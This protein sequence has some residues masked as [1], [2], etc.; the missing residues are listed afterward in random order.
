MLVAF[1][2]A[3][4]AQVSYLDPLIWVP[5]HWRPIGRAVRST[6]GKDEALLKAYISLTNATGRLSLIV[7]LCRRCYNML[8]YATVCVRACFVK[9]HQLDATFLQMV[10]AG[11]P[12]LVRAL[13]E[14]F[15]ISPSIVKEH[16]A[17]I[18]TVFV[19]KVCICS[20]AFVYD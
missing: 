17:D 15:R 11:S 1:T 16:A 3:L 8:K 14:G 6:I 5:T 9:Y 7:R 19:E 10:V 2:A 4:I 13:L 18:L 12:G 20:K